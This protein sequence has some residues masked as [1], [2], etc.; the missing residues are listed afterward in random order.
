[1][2]LN[3]QI[4]KMISTNIWR[5]FQKFIFRSIFKQVS[6]RLTNIKV[7]QFE[8]NI[9]QELTFINFTFNFLSLLLLIHYTSFTLEQQFLH[10]LTIKSWKNWKPNYSFGICSLW[11]FGSIPYMCNLMKF[12]LRYK[13][14]WYHLKK[15]F[16]FMFSF[17]YGS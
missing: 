8:K 13:D 1:M 12:C 4:T 16:L 2:F 10:I 7:W 6:D 14:N 5:N 9:C 3:H 11:W 15:E 17:I